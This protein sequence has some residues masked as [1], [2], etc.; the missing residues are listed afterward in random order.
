MVDHRFGRVDVF[1]LGIIHHAPAERNDIAP[2]I[3][4]GHH[5][6]VAE[7][8]VG[9]LHY[10]RH[11]GFTEPELESSGLVKRSAKG[12]LYDIFRHRV[13]VPIIDVRDLW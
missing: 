9:L 12:N 11:R 5:H 13:M 3:N 6:A 4:D 7:D 1:R 2:H 10:L 8:F